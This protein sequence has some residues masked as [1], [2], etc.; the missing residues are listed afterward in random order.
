MRRS[1]A[2]LFRGEIYPEPGENQPAFL[3]REPVASAKLQ[4]AMLRSRKRLWLLALLPVVGSGWA[5]KS[6]ASWRP[7]VFAIEKDV[8]SVRLSPDGKTL[9]SHDRGGS[10][11]AWDVDTAQSRFRNESGQF[12]EIVFSPGSTCF[13]AFNGNGVDSVLRFRLWDLKSGATRDFKFPTG[14]NLDGKGT[15]HLRDDVCD[16]GFSADGK[17]FLTAIHQSLISTDAKTGRLL[18]V[19]KWK[20]NDGR[21]AVA[22]VQGFIFPQRK[23]FV[24]ERDDYPNEMVLFDIRTGREIRNLGW[25]EDFTISPD[26][27]TFWR[28]DQHITNTYSCHRLSDLKE[29]WHVPSLPTFSPDGRLAYIPSTTGLDVLDAHTGAKLRHLPGPLSA[30]FAPSPDGNW[31]YEARDGK[32]WK[33]RAR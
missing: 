4:G 27:Y 25:G 29:M 9:V 24:G 7:Q 8:D 3:R 18:S 26:E 14:W 28:N 33:W 6:V 31:L 5:M 13:A 21:D 16:F 12:G 23:A 30:N 10:G 19:H 1:V 22:V 17:I 2:H 11:Y 20:S 32:I 15:M